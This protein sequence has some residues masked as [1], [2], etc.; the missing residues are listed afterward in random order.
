MTAITETPAHLAVRATLDTLVIAGKIRTYG[1]TTK[2]RYFIR[3][4]DG[5]RIA[6]MTVTRAADFA[7]FAASI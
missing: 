5:R 4:V 3:T 6:N 7:A 2:G 1:L